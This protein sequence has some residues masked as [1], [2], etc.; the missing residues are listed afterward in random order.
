MKLKQL[1]LTYLLLCTL[2]LNTALAQ[3]TLT[4]MNGQTLRDPYG[5][6]IDP[7]TQPDNLKNDSTNVQ[8]PP[9]RLYQWQLDERPKHEPCRRH[10]GTL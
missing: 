6:Q 4:N 8:A 2:G 7:S 3:Q 5:N 9:P 1:T 10:G